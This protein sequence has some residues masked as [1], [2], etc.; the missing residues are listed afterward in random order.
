M[1]GLILSFIAKLGGT[2]TGYLFKKKIADVVSTAIAAK[3]GKDV[4]I[5]ELQTG[6][7][8][9][10]T[11]ADLLKSFRW[12]QWL[13]LAA[14]IPP[15]M[16]QGAVFLDSTPFPYITFEY[17]MPVIETHVTGS[18]RVPKAPPPYDEREWQLIA[19]LLGIQGGLSVGMAFLKFL[20]TRR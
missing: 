2:V 16:H 18:W 8:L 17:L 4:I 13:I 3:V 6:A 9:F 5:A 10:K 11:R 19:S 20:F 15:V 12:T 7:E 1:F 14:L